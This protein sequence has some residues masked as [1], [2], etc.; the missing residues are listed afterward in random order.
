MW[1]YLA[2]HPGVSLDLEHMR[3]GYMRVDGEVDAL[4]PNYTVEQCFFRQMGTDN[5]FPITCEQ[6]GYR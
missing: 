6:A 5:W 2:L 3:D 4:G 1:T